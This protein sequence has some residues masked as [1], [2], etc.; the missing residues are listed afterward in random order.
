M[1]SVASVRLRFEDSDKGSDVTQTLTAEV[2]YDVGQQ[3]AGV[4]NNVARDQFLIQQR[5]NF[6]RE[7]AGT[8]TKVRYLIV[9]G[10]VMYAVGLVMFAYGFISFAIEMSQIDIS[11]P[12]SKLPTPFGKEIFGVPVWLLGW[13][14]GVMGSFAM[15]VGLVL[16]VVATSRRRQVER[17][18]GGWGA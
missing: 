9:L 4:I 2:H 8:R 12:P 15:I 11:N 14:L 5:E 3:Q 17:E 10:F 1:I 6:L 7:V 13:A 18:Y 16:H